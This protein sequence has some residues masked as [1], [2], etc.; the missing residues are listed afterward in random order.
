MNWLVT[1]YSA[2]LFFLLTP[3][4]LLRLPNGGNKYV[5]AGV[6]AIVFALL[7]HFT[8]SMVK[9]LGMREGMSCPPGQVRHGKGCQASFL[10]RAPVGGAL[11]R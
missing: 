11:K 3:A 4:I 1:I 10:P 9:G 7:F 6:H 8:S 2:V 5:V